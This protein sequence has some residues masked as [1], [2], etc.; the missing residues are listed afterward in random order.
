MQKFFSLVGFNLLHDRFIFKFV[1][2]VF[3]NNQCA[4][5]DSEF[6]TQI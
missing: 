1:I 5:T 6:I 3:S 2:N 4:Y